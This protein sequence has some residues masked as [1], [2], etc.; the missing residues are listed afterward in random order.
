LQLRLPP[1]YRARFDPDILV[2]ETADG[3]VVAR[4]GVRVLAAEEVE[5]SVPEDSGEAAKSVSP[6]RSSGRRPPSRAR[7]RPC[8]LAR[9]DERRLDGGSQPAP[10]AVGFGASRVAWVAI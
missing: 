3:S 2:L 7:V 10:L 4:F 8:R 1:G 6:R 5:R 9:P